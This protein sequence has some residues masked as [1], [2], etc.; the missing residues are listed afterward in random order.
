M[1]LCLIENSNQDSDSSSR[2]GMYYKFQSN[3]LEFIQKIYKNP[4]EN[5]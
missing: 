1:D 4:G 2:V 3:F 5:F